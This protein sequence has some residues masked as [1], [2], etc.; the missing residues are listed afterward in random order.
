MRLAFCYPPEERI[1]AGV[2]R[3]GELLLDQAER[4]RS[5]QGG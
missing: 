3:L 1:R 5:L 4:Y 2:G